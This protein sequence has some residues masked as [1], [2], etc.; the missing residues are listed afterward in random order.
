MKVLPAIFFIVCIVT[1]PQRISAAQKSRRWWNIKGLFLKDQNLCQAR[2][3]RKH[4]YYYSSSSFEPHLAAV[5]TIRWKGIKCWCAVPQKLLSLIEES[6]GA[7]LAKKYRR[8]N[9]LGLTGRV[10]KRIMEKFA[11]HY[12]ETKR[13]KFPIFISQAKML[14]ESFKLSELASESPSKIIQD[15]LMIP[16]PPAELSAVASPEK[17]PTPPQK[18]STP[19]KRTETPPKI[20]VL[21][22]P[23][24]PEPPKPKEP[25]FP[26][27]LAEAAAKMNAVNAR[28]GVD[29]DEYKNRKIERARSQHLREQGFL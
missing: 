11:A 27:D 20:E 6:Y 22:P 17:V 19:P 5:A 1:V 12:I 16:A 4:G 15:T 3:T 23:P 14:R 18:I 28:L 25:E 2:C 9:R 26:P 21:P 7:A 8:Y 13:A 10:R 29:A 24:P